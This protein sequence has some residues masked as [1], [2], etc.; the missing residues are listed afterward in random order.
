[1]IS[2]DD[3]KPVTLGDKNLFDK[4]YERYPPVHSDYVFTTIIS[5]MEYAKYH[6]VFLKNNLII[7]TKL[8]NELKFRPP[9]G[10]YDTDIFQQVFKLA[11]REGNAYPLSLIDTQSRDFLSKDYKAK[12]NHLYLDIYKLFS[13]TGMKAGLGYSH[14]DISVMFMYVAI[15]KYL[16]Q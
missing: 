15:D 16:K 3:F 13:H 7:M 4:H 12:L 14:D 2:I 1:M 9:V 6:Y 10:K 8:R 5:W 11:K